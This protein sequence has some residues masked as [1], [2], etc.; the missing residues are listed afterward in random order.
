MWPGWRER[1]EPKLPKRRHR[2]AANFRRGLPLPIQYR[3]LI[4]IALDR[5]TLR[6]I[7]G[8]AAEDPRLGDGDRAVVRRAAWDAGRGRGVAA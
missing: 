6:E 2:T 3:V 5:P 7:D 1:R 8:Q 4:G